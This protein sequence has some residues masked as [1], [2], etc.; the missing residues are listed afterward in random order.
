M[1][2]DM[3]TNHTTS[4]DTMH[5]EDFADLVAGLK[6]VG[7]YRASGYVGG[8]NALTGMISGIG[9]TLGGALGYASYKP[10]FKSGGLY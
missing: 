10:A 3:T 2:D 4:D 9:D 1:S 7:A 5:E 8:T 6:D